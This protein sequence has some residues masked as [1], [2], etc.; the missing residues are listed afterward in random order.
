MA[1]RNNIYLLLEEIQEQ[2]FPNATV[3]EVLKE[4]DR[5]IGPFEKLSDGEFV[6]RLSGYQKSPFHVK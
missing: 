4:L 1:D 3:G 2:V 6:T 5:L